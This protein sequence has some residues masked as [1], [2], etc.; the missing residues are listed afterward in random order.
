MSYCKLATSATTAATVAAIAKA[1]TPAAVTA[2]AAAQWSVSNAAQPQQNA[3][4][5]V[6][7]VPN[8]TR[9][10]IPR[11][12]EYSASMYAKTPEEHAHYLQYY[13]QYYTDQL[14]SATTSAASAANHYGAEATTA[15]APPDLSKFT[16]D[17][18][19]GYYYDTVSNL[20]YDSQTQYF[21]NPQTQLFSYWDYEKNSFVAVPNAGNT[22][23]KA[24]AAAA[25]GSAAD[26]EEKKEKSGKQDKV[27]SSILFNLIRADSFWFYRLLLPRK[28]PR[29][30]K[31]GPR[32]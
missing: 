27:F 19:S 24:G 2:V 17:E 23:A 14:Q 4:A 9:E 28:S 29:T 12:A 7:E 32:R 3:P 15:A 16:Y 22:D 10:E 5:A 6:V 8:F 26:K 25:G 31:N 30:W 11:L 13:T 20:Y 1:G 18:K 21:Y